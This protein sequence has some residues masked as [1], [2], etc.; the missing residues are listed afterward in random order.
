MMQDFNRYSA[1]HL[2]SQLRKLRNRPIVVFDVETNGLS[3]RSSV[4]SISAM[5]YSFEE[6]TKSLQLIAQFERYYFSLET[7]NRRA[8]AVNGLYEEVIKQRRGTAAYP[9]Y[10]Q[11]DEDV[12]SF[13]ADAGLL[14]AHNVDFDRQFLVVFPELQN[15]GYFCTMKAYGR[16]R[17]L[18]ELARSEGM[19]VDESRL[20]ES[21]YDC[22]LAAFLLER[23]IQK[24]V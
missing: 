24:T 6:K 18:H 15:L 7:P 23:I 14:V 9:Y 17:K 16:Y 19:R 21:S 8:L 5:K 13:F 22:E 12:P 2:G 3:P 4:L 1:A 10:F 11:D 20:H